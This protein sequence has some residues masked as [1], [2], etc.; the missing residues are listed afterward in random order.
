MNEA[1]IIIEHVTETKLS[2]DFIV[3]KVEG[4]LMD[5]TTVSCDNIPYSYEVISQSDDAIISELNC[6]AIINQTTIVDDSTNYT[7]NYTVQC[8]NFDPFKNSP[9]WI[10][11]NY[12]DSKNND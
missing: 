8:E 9:K 6:D 7:C 10:N 12:I 4:I 3:L 1:H 11:V 5:E 2:L